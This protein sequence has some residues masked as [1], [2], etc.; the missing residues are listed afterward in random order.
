M[1]RNS[2]AVAFALAPAALVMTHVL[3]GSLGV[4]PL[5]NYPPYRSANSKIEGWLM[6]GIIFCFACPKRTMNPLQGLENFGIL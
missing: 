3:F 6:S 5:L 4:F 2:F 1:P